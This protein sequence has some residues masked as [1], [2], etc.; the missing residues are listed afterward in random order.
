[1]KSLYLFLFSFLLFAGPVAAQYELPDSTAFEGIIIE[2]YYVSDTLDVTDEDGGFL[3]TCS[4]TYRVFID[5]KPDYRLQ[6]V[7]GNPNN[8]LRIETSSEFFNNEDRGEETGDVIGDN[9][10]GDNTV[11]LDSWLTMGAASEA[12]WGIPKNLDTDGS[13]IGGENSDGGSEEIEGG[14]LVNAD[15][16]VEIPLTTADGLLAGDV[17]SVTTVGVDLAVFG[18]ENDGPLFET[19]SGAWSVLEGVTGPTDDNI[20]LIAQFTTQGELSLRLNIQ[21]GIP[22]E[23]QCGHPDCH[24]TMQFVAELHPD[25]AA[26][27]VENDNI[28]ERPEL[29]Y[30]SE[31]IICYPTTN[32]TEANAPAPELSLYPNPANEQLTI[33]LTQFTAEQSDWTVF[34]ALG[35]TVASGAFAP[36]TGTANHYLNTTEWAPGSYVIMVHSGTQVTS[37]TFIVQ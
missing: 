5:L 12:H 37:K 16:N 32:I 31:P 3:D 36:Y 11:A 8:T 2:R 21:V 14:I 28:F 25:D 35:E 24:T 27:G 20:I 23:L 15:D 33:A 34:N 13:I 22:A 6:A 17:P 30:T 26:P 7:Y 19:N 18:D 29:L 10:L 1:M 4:V 9:F